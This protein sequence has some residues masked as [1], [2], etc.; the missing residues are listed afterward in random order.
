[1]SKFLSEKNKKRIMQWPEL[2]PGE[3]PPGRVAHLV[4]QH[5]DWCALLNEKGECNCNPT[6]TRHLQPKEL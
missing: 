3:Y 6:I 2:P 4:V 1:M 5:D